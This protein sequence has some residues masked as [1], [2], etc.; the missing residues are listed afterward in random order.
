M[1]T[2]LLVFG[3]LAGGVLLSWLRSDP[4]E[5]S[6]EPSP[7][8]SPESSH[9]AKQPQ[10]QAWQPSVSVAE[11][12][13]K[14]DLV[15]KQEPKTQRPWAA[16]PEAYVDVKSEASTEVKPMSQVGVVSQRVQP[17]LASKAEEAVVRP[18]P[19][20]PPPKLRKPDLDLT[21]YKELPKK[22]LLLPGELKEKIAVPLPLMNPGHISSVPETLIRTPPQKTMGS[23]PSQS[24]VATLPSQRAVVAPPYRRAVATPPFQK[25][26]DA[27]PQRAVATLPSQRSVATSL[28]SPRAVATPPSQPMM[29]IPYQSSAATSPY[30]SSAATSPYQRAVA[31]LSS[32]RAVATPSSRKAVATS[33]YRTTVV[34]PY[35]EAIDR[36][37]SQKSTGTP[38]SQRAVS[39][40]S[41]RKTIEAPRSK[42]LASRLPQKP[43][44][45]VRAKQGGYLVQVAVFPNANRALKVVARL[46]RQGGTPHMETVKRSSG[47]S[48]F[49]IRF[50]PFST[51]DEAS[52]ALKR[53][54][55]QGH[56]PAI[57][58]LGG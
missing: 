53:W 39:P 21:F 11:T 46:R 28:P 10:G 42:R 45:T 56:A 52:K 1:P 35:Q 23:P 22:K 29:G 15:P 30:Q 14:T 50:G 18:L 32:Q 12:K 8:L 5:P 33:P 36:L 16:K 41:S 40:P 48:I 9:I 2:K 44:Q 3:L 37:L 4:P 7:G 26:M 24:A 17:S 13:S 27:P 49:Q 51:Y 31:A 6:P 25:T 43:T 57:V 58:R 47:G 19:K 34:T 38:P 54:R 55:I 20:M